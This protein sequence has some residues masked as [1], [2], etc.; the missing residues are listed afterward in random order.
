V[1]VDDDRQGVDLIVRGRDLLAATPAQIRLGR[2]L[3][4]DRPAAYLHH[5]LIVRP[6]GRKLSKS[7][8]DTGVR[9]L[10]AAGWT[11]AEVIGAAATA[12]GDD[13]LARFVG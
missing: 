2:L 4:R 6:D 7:A 5:P 8:G 9:E 13:G 10:R 3:G 1:V 11:A 12:M